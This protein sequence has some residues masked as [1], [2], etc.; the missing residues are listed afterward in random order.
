[1]DGEEENKKGCSEERGVDIVIG[2]KGSKRREERKGENRVKAML[3]KESGGREGL[4]K[5]DRN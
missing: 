3:E 2:R 1:M 4:E 5:Y